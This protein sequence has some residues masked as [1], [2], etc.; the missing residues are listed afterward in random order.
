MAQTAPKRKLSVLKR[1]RQEKKRNLRNR[2]VLSKVRTY[3][4]RLVEAVESGNGEQTENALKAA[5]KVIDTASSKGVIHKNT[6]SRKISRL[7]LRA[8]A[9]LKN[10]TA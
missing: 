4:R 3:I 2:A 1:A 6:A 8:N 5:V 7:T 9:V 10:Q